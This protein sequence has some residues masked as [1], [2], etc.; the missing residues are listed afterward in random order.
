METILR[1]KIMT[2]LLSNKLISIKQ[3]GFTPGRSCVTQ[4]LDTLDHWTEILD[5]GGSVDVVY[6]D[7]RKAFDSVPHRRLTQ[8]V[9]AHGIKGNLLKWIQD[10][11]S[12]RT[13]QVSIPP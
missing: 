2:H 12:E 5:R 3:H 11:L 4:L 6:M 10:F 1:E 8:K 9:E 13:Q 7:F